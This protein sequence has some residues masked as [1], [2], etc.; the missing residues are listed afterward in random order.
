MK[1]VQDFIEEHID[2][3]GCGIRQLDVA[4][5][6]SVQNF[7]LLIWRQGVAHRLV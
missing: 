1:G 2:R 6:E 4:F 3:L 5:L 7:V